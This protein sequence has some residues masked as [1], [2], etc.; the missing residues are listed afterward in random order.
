MS[1]EP[2]AKH[3]MTSCAH[4]TPAANEDALITEHSKP[5]LSRNATHE[6]AKVNIATH[7]WFRRMTKAVSY[8]ITHK[9][10]CKPATVLP[11]STALQSSPATNI[12]D[13]RCQVWVVDGG[14]VVWMCFLHPINFS[15]AAV[16]F[17]CASDDL[18]A[19]G[20]L[21]ARISIDRQL[22]TTRQKPPFQTDSCLSSKT[23]PTGRPT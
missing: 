5:H 7:M 6:L 19:K 4:S 12:F 18:H 8:G 3:N 13:K 1:L 17:G 22:N 10:S 23:T 14:R 15:G 9:Y 11:A 20:L 2:Q 21:S 16:S